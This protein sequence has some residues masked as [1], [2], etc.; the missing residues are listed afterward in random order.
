MQGLVLYLIFCV[1]ASHGTVTSTGILTNTAN[2]GPYRPFQLYLA[3]ILF[4]S[5]YAL[6][7]AMLH[8]RFTSKEFHSKE[9]IVLNYSRENFLA[10]MFNPEIR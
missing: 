1:S 5:F 8:L 6:L 10:Q 4:G 3:F 2:Q 9:D 7:A